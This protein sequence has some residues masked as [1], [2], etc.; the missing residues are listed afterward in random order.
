M[1]FSPQEIIP[2]VW[3]N[4]DNICTKRSRAGNWKNNLAS[5]LVSATLRGV[6]ATLISV[7]PLATIVDVHVL[8]DPRSFSK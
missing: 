2:F 1:A 8:Q 5:K 4:W 3:D 7:L 6:L